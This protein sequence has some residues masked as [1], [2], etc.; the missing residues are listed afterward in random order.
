MSDP[1]PIW[2]DPPTP[3][4]TATSNVALRVGSIGLGLVGAALVATGSIWIGLVLS[5]VG[6][7]INIADLAMGL[8]SSGIAA[9][10]RERQAGAV[11]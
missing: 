1:G 5:L 2:S 7:G 6:I 8:R 10:E 3:P 11:Q 4:R 9:K